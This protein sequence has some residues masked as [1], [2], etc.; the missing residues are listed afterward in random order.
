MANTNPAI[1][2][3]MVLMVVGFMVGAGLLALGEFK[4]TMETDSAE[5]NAT[6][7]AITGVSNFT[8]LLPTVGTMIGIALLLLVVGV[9]FAYFQGW[10]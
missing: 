9:A 4:D 2:L 10:I 5:Y 1:D 3:V 8:D 6:G 7:Q